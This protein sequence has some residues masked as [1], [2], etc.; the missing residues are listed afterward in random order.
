M[1]FKI[2]EQREIISGYYSETFIVEAENREEA[3][4]KLRNPDENEEDI[5]YEDTEFDIRDSEHLYF[6]D[7]NL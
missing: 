7:E 3:L 6:E 4:E 1:K 2:T 5:E